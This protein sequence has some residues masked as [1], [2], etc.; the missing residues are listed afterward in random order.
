ME[1]IN[2]IQQSYLLHAK[3]MLDAEKEKIEKRKLIFLEIKEGIHAIETLNSAFQSD[4]GLFT[5]FTRPYNDD[6]LEQEELD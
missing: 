4:Y 3:K 2:S 6:D 1:E 5:Q